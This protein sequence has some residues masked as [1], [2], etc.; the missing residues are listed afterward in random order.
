MKSISQSLAL[1]TPLI[2]E[3]GNLSGIAGLSLG[4]VHEGEVTYLQNA[5][6]RDVA[7]KLYTDSDTVYPIGSLSKAFTAA[8]VGLLVE[9]GKLDWTTPLQNVLP[10]FRSSYIEVQNLTTP[11]DLLSHR[12]GLPGLE[13]LWYHSEPLLDDSQIY[14]TFSSIPQT[15]PFRTV[16]QY[17]N[18][19]YA[20]IGDLVKHIS[21]RTVEKLLMSKIFHPLGMLRTK[22]NFEST[23]TNVAISYKAMDDGSNFPYGNDGSGKAP[24]LKLQEDFRVPS[25]TF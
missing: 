4:V 24:I 15:R 20:I 23:T 14:D 17:N 6:F 13:T 10:K 9:D 22:T 11:L 5:G 16:M 19:G 21:G 18:L 7:Q 25:T 8:G 1:L 12:T 3:I 2:H